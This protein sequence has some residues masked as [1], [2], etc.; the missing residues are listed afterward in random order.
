MPANRKMWLASHSIDASFAPG[1]NL[2]RAG[3]LAGALL[4][5]C[6]S[7][8][9]FVSSNFYIFRGREEREGALAKSRGQSFKAAEAADGHVDALKRLQ[10]SHL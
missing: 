6:L 8:I 3:A 2:G 7:S 10:H 4:H 9:S 5:P 1:G